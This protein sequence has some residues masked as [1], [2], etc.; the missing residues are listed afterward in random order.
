MSKHVNCLAYQIEY[1]STGTDIVLLCC[2]E[3]S[4]VLRYSMGHG[5]VVF[6]SCYMITET[7]VIV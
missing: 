6:G 4:I 1:N 5:I 7:Y 3:L 2:T